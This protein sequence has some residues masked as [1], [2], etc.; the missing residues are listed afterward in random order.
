[1]KK[2]GLFI[3]L[4]L[5]L[6]TSWAEVPPSEQ[7]KISRAVFTSSV[8]NH[9]P[10]D[11][12]NILS[13]L[14]S[15]VFYFTEF[16]NFQGQTLIHE[17]SHNG[18]LSHRIRFAITGKRWRVHSSKAFK[19]GKAQ[20]GTW[21]VKI[22]D[23][24]GTVLRENRIDYIRPSTVS[25]IEQ[26]AKIAADKKLQAEI[27]TEKTETTTKNPTAATTEPTPAAEIRDNSSNNEAK[28]SNTETNNTVDKKIEAV[29]T[30]ADSHP[31]EESNDTSSITTDSNTTP[32]TSDQRPIW[33]KI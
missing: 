23:E 25:E 29:A 14:I 31:A 12:L 10:I 18:K 22:L 15:E 9:E 4:S 24:V 3:I 1:M 6:H 26:A 2:I 20:E 7:G 19:L 17:W 28:K 33:D 30:K 32:T 8:Q 13:Q 11:Q 16:K 21:T 5:M 27:T